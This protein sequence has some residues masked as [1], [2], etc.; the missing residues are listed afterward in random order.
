MAAGIDVDGRGPGEWHPRHQGLGGHVV[1]SNLGSCRNEQAVT[2]A[3]GRGVAIVPARFHGG[4][5]H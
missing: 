2:L 1:G 3:C 4:R 5:G